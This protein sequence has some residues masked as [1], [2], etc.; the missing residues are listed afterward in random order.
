MLSAHTPRTGIKPLK[1]NYLHRFLFVAVAMAACLSSCVKDKFNDVELAYHGTAAFPVATVG[2]TLAEVLKNDTLLTI[3]GDNSISL[4]YRQDNF[5]TITAAE[6][7]EDLTGGIH[8][9]FAQTTKVG[10]TGIGD[11]YEQ[12]D[13]PF[14]DLVEDFQNQAIKQ[15][16][17]QNEGSMMP[18]PAFQ[19]TFSSEVAVP[20]FSDFNWL[21]IKTGKMALTVKNELF[22]D[23]Q[24]LKVTVFDNSSNQAV[25][26]FDF[27]S[28]PKGGSLTKELNLQDKSIG[29]DF[30]VEI[31]S[32]QTPGSGGS[33]VLIDL[34]KKL[35]CT[36]DVRDVTIEAGEAV[37][38]SGVLAQDKLQFQFNMT[39]GERIHQIALNSVQAAYQ[40][41]S[42]VKTDVRLKL[43][44]PHIFKNNN[45]VVH[46][47]TV[48]PGGPLTG[49]LDFSNTV[50]RL[51][52]VVAQPYNRMDVDYEVYLQNATGSPV[53]FSSDD[54]VSINFTVSD[55]DVEEARGFFGFRE[56]H[57]ADGALDFGFDF[58]LFD[59]SSSPL[60]FENPK[61]N[62]EVANSF[63]IPLKVDF[64]VTAQGAFGGQ[65]SLDPPKLTIAYPEMNEVGETKMSEFLIFKNNSKIVDMLS[66]Y[67]TSITYGGHAIINPAND[68]QT[69]NFVRSDSKLTA[70]A[71]LDLPFRFRV[72]D[73]VYRDTGD[74]LA[75]GLEK[76]LTTDDIESAELKILYTNG[77]PLKTTVRIIALAADGSETV[78][79]DGVSIDAATV[80]SG[81]KVTGKASGELFATVSRDQIGQLDSAV[82]N[83][84]EVRFQTGDNG[85]TPAAMYTDYD[86]ELKIGM[87][88]KFDK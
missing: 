56:E 16:L 50:W 15:M 71:E 77:M 23:L 45:P 57:F 20:A 24:N 66:V 64:N 14:G 65:V 34:D 47:I 62:I 2:F 6:L 51:D 3:G 84:Y 18:I 81:G 22:V 26:T 54:E 80:G 46:E 41:T 4:V 38:P 78:V 55:F 8:E 42:E 40:I 88:V 5:F 39:N 7:L 75:L 61:M 76:G 85:Q 74:A 58:S 37:L 52:Q 49:Q 12:F 33:S 82:K 29:N 73:L 79:L 87:T 86:V 48:S 25:G 68:P 11:V 30:K 31:T 21:D 10:E 36:L 59:P 70:S 69:V 35:R 63:G 19:E 44:F 9:N 72:Q 17:E 43:V 83:I 32:L 1:L 53:L 60:L 13:L 67:P 27:N 28:L